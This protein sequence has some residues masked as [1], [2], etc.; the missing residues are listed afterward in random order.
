MRKVYAVQDAKAGM[1]NTPIFLLSDGEALRS[2]IDACRP[3]NDQSMLSRHPE[4][5]NLFYIG[6]YDETEGVLHSAV[7]YHLANGA[8]ILGGD[9]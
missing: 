6:D 8:V 2:F 1:F 3:G 9:R 7:P 4:D 5:F